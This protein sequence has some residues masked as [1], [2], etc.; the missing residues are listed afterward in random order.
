[1]LVDIKLEPQDAFQI[2]RN[3][4]GT[5]RLTIPLELLIRSHA[6]YLANKPRFDDAAKRHLNG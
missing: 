4:D 1:M 6:T 5:T 2:T 3:A